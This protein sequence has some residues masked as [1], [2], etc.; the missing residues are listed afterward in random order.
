MPEPHDRDDADARARHWFACQQSRMLSEEERL[1]LANWLA[2]SPHH[3][4]AWLRVERDWQSLE[5]FRVG[6]AGELAKAR[7]QRPWYRNSVYF[8]GV[9]AAL[10]LAILPLLH[11]GWTGTNQSWQTEVGER[12]HL[13][14][15]DGSQLDLDTATRITITQSWFKRLIQ[16]QEGE[17]YLEVGQDWRPL[18]V[19][20]ADT[21][22]RDIGTRFSVRNTAGEFTVQVAEGAVEIIHPDRNILLRSGEMAAHRSIDNQ[23]RLA[24]LQG[25]IANWRQGV[26]V[27]N[28][29]P[30]SDV[31]R[32]LARYHVIQLD[33]ADPNL[34]K[35]QVS[36]RFRLDEL[37]TTLCIIAETLNLQVEHPTPDRFR[38]SPASTRSQAQSR[39]CR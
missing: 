3:Y 35:K 19:M 11:Y 24:T 32:E 28:R 36:G 30:L 15:A 21:R 6:L 22:V 12:Q 14:L 13:V 17:I 33:L 20:A 8:R 25:E 4:A 31:L 39:P 16:L 37:N 27:F 26:L 18:V 9:L 23:W 38:L 29:H 7:R 2:A 1:A 34:A 5:R 10:V